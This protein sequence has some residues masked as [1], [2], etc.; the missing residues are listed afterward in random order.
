MAKLAPLLAAFA[1]FLLVANAS[2]YQTTVEI[3]E[4]VDPQGQHCQQQRLRHCQICRCLRLAQALRCQQQQGA[5]GGQQEMYE[6]ASETPRM[7]QMQPMRR[8]D[9]ELYA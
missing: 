6:T 8:D 4:N 1:L 3:D 9:E 7:C 2:M 5:H